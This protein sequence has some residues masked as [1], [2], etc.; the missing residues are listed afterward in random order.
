VKKPAFAKSPS[1]GFGVPGA[2]ARQAQRL[3]TASFMPPTLADE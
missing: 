2:T 1:P 3:V